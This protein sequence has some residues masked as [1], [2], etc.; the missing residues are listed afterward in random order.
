[1]PQN[2]QKIHYQGKPIVRTEHPH[3][4]KVKGVASSTLDEAYASQGKSHYGIIFTDQI[5]PIFS[6]VRYVEIIN[7]GTELPGT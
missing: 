4:V 1:M 7:L 5:F 6:Y 3:I 2:T